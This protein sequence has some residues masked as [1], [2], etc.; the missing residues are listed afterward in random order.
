MNSF[1]ARSTLRVAD[2]EYEIYRPLAL[3]D[4]FDIAR[5]PFSIRILL[6]N[7]LRTEDGVAVSKADIEALAGWA[8]D[9]VPRQEKKMSS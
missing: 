4:R 7:L 6:E 5:L 2:R 8:P 3:A 1:D 9:N